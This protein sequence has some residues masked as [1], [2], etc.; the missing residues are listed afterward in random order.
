MF[1]VRLGVHVH[2]SP[3]G[4]YASSFTETRYSI[5]SKIVKPVS[6]C[7]R[8]KRSGL[9]SADSNVIRT[10]TEGSPTSIL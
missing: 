6:P 8:N 1:M 9:G 2:I 4:I 10:G 7:A 5:R 3:I